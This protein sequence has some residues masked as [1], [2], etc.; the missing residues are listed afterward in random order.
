[1][2]E[3]F[4][5]ISKFS[6]KGDQP[7]AIEQLSEGYDKYA[8]QVLLGITG[9][10]KTFTI[11]NVINKINKPTLVLVHNKTLAFQCC[12]ELK[13]LFPNNRVEYFV[14]YFDYYQPESYMPQTDTYIEK[15][16]RVNQQI[17]M[18]RLKATASL[19]S[20]NDV[21]IVSSISCI[22]GIG[23]PS[24]WRDMAFKI[25]VGAKINRPDFY[26]SL[27]AMQYERNDVALEP[28]RFRV[29][30][31]T[32]DLILG[33]EKNIYRINFLGDRIIRI[34]ELDHVSGNKV[35]NL[36]ELMIFPARHYVVPEERID[37]AIESI[38]TELEAHAP[39][40]PLLESRR[41]T[42]R[43][44]YDLEMIEEVG[45]CKGI[46]NY[47]SHFENRAKESHPYCLLDFFP[48]DFLLVIDESHQS[49]PQ[50]HAMYPGDR[51]R[52]KNLIEHGFRLPT[53]YG[54]RPLKFEEFEK[55]F[56][57][58]V[59]VSA[60]PGE[61]EIKTSCQIVKQIIRP[62]GLLDPLVE[63]KQATGQVDDLLGEIQE[64]IKDKSRVLVTTLTKRMAED[65]TE[66]LSKAG[67]RVR[68]LHSEIDSI[69]R[70][71][72]IRQLRLGEFD[73]LVGINLLREGLD[74][75]EVSLVAI[76][77]ADQEGFLRDERSLIQTIGRA[78]R[79]DQGRVILYADKITKSI[80]RAVEIT[81]KRRQHQEEFNK[82][83][84]IIPKTI[85]KV[86]PDS[87]VK[88]KTL[89]HMAKS[90]VPSYI[91]QLEAQMYAAAENL[92]F[93]KALELREQ[94]KELKNKIK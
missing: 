43:T 35:A 51:A 76:L 42:Q 71:E 26:R 60:T 80:K 84:G 93:E 86:I 65:L 89:K 77:D 81:K 4:E 41:I 33:Y 25:K 16:S 91:S 31:N 73:V 24:D 68:Y 22:Y 72:I 55:F 85:I 50:S 12:S 6:P 29:R 46:E 40:L 2:N 5:L 1:M 8:R 21:I 18:M 34:S 61:Y 75:P 48:K 14:S 10:G 28:G 92:E 83:N 53:A 23:S 88:V 59:F 66:Y 78:A 90:Q 36:E 32:T 58:V 62:T 94:I 15:D 56:N 37:M 13:E 44:K 47:S 67:V 79:N 74:I 70:T 45:Y 69:Q 9:S 82:K 30:G 17:E 19:L 20:R 39:T 7:K 64:T 3:K 57:H 27:V 87:E 11:A 49:L 52:K 54:N 38:K 63:I